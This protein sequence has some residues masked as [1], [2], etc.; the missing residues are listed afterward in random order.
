MKNYTA[1]IVVIGLI[2]SGSLQAGIALDT[3]VSSEATSLSGAPSFGKY[4]GKSQ[5]A[6][7]YELSAQEAKYLK[8]P[9]CLSEFVPENHTSSKTSTIDWATEDEGRYLSD[10]TV[11]GEWTNAFVNLDSVPVLWSANDRNNRGTPLSETIYS[12]H[13][14]I[15]SQQFSGIMTFY[16]MNAGSSGAL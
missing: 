2:L 7:E 1:F 8:S 15:S 13:N 16:S 4:V 5:Y 12:F 9:F 3:T 10:L 11:G 14:R 6:E